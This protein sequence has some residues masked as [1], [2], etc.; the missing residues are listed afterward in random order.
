MNDYHPRLARPRHSQFHA[1]IRRPRPG[2]NQHVHL[3]FCRFQFVECLRVLPRRCNAFVSLYRPYL[4]VCSY[5]TS[6]WGDWITNCPTNEVSNGQYVSSSMI[7][8]MSAHNLLQIPRHNSSRHRR[9]FVGLSSSRE[10]R[11]IHCPRCSHPP[12]H[13]LVNSMYLPLKTSPRVVSAFMLS[14]F[15]LLTAP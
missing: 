6:S 1:N 7:P 13:R 14:Y 9:T 11:V 12:A 4:L 10:W 2:P 15:L 3:Q 5:T 8:N